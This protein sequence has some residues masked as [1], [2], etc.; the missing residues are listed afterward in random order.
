MD[1][2]EEKS[3]QSLVRKSDWNRP[4]GR[5]R[6]YVIVDLGLEVEE[7]IISLTFSPGES[8]CFL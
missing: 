8:M 5:Q 1:G 4:L 6:Y 7:R 2:K 3:V